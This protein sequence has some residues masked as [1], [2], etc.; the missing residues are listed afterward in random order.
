MN[1]IKRISKTTVTALNPN[2]IV[3]D[4]ILKGFIA[5]RR[6]NTVTFFVAT[7]INGVSTW[8]TIGKHGSPW[9]AEQARSRA[10]EL[11]YD[12]RKG[13]RPSKP[14][15]PERNATEVVIFETAFEEYVTSR[16]G[17]IKQSTLDE[18]KRIA[19]ASLYP[20]FGQRGVK[21][22]TRAEI[23]TMHQNGVMTPGAANHILTVTKIFM[24]WLEAEGYRDQRS[25]PCHKI[26]KY[27]GNKRATFLT[28][29]DM[30]RLAESMRTS[31]IL[32]EAST[33]QIAAI[34][35]LMF[36]GARRTEI[37]TLK[38]S[39]VDQQ[40]MLAHLPDSKT[41]AK[42]L[43]LNAPAMTIL[44]SLMEYPN[45]PYYF[46]GRKPN[47]CISEI[48]KPWDKIRKRAG[49]ERFRLHDF[50]HSFASFA[51]DSGADAA[52]IGKLLG[53]ASIETTK[54]YVHL[55]AKKPREGANA[56]G[57]TI[58]NLM[59]GSSPLLSSTASAQES[60]HLNRQGH[61]EQAPFFP[62]HCG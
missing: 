2:D 58:H 31:L 54:L 47:S 20:L 43:H 53:H 57:T 19:K 24:N 7:R 27:P 28:Y 1:V 22:I 61:T 42:V 45:N 26:K 50:R 23:K 36:T 41:G 15:P 55:F 34:L 48:K 59:I 9:T 52:A 17:H 16:I 13:I 6:G 40:R 33:T 25:N 46:V 14:T 10:Q 11:L 35:L 30:P 4:D 39:Y 29:E 44:D 60:K 21:T 32:G 3:R 56:T 49:L 12:A 62:A 8:L 18:Y 51:A 37:F 38:R 5:R